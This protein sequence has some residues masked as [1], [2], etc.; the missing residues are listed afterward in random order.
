[1]RRYVDC[2]RYDAGNVMKLG[3]RRSGMRVVQGFLA[4]GLILVLAPGS[5]RAQAPLGPYG[6]FGPRPTVSPYLNLLRRDT[7]QVLNY[8][9]LVRPQQQFNANLQ[10]LYQQQSL[11]TQQ[12][13]AASEGG[14]LLPIT[15]HQTRFLN[16]RHPYFGSGGGQAPANAST[17]R[18]A[19]ASPQF[20][21]PRAPTSA[22]MVSRF[23]G[24]R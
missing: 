2:S 17:A 22:G 1:M 15:G 11:I 9:G 10:N 12:A 23:S 16:Q 6:P 14:Q 13:L 4:L 3:R 18:P 8:Y 19:M 7:P 5:V 21:G 20:A 24:A